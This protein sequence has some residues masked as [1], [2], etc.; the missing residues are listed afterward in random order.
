M[1]GRLYLNKVRLAKAYAEGMQ[2]ETG[3]V[4][5]HTTGSPAYVAWAAGYAATDCT[6]DSGSCRCSSGGVAP[7]GH[8]V[9]P[10]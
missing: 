6:G 1:P 10:P 9:T 5:P 8:P 4:N 3:A 2:A 7:D